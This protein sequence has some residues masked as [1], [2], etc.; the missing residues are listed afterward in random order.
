[1]QTVNVAVPNAHVKEKVETLEEAHFE[2]WHHW[3]V[4]WSAVWVGALASIGAALIFG[5]V[6]LALGAHVI[7]PEHRLVDL[8]KLS[9]GAMIFSVCGAFFAFAIGGWITG[10]VAGN[11]YAEPAILHGAIAWLVAIPLLVGFVA[12]GAG[13]YL[14][15][16]YSGL[17]GTP[18]WAASAALPFDR[19]DPLPPNAT[20]EDV[21]KYRQE[22]AAYRDRVQQWKDDTPKVTRN[23]ALGAVTALLLGLVGS[24][25]GGWVA[26]GEPM[27]FTH[28]R[29]R[30]L[31]PHHPSMVLRESM[32]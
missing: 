19:P 31:M 17:G 3:H 24:V 5:L 20:S 29:T 4:N 16:W 7:D 22:M 18:S 21:T 9:I 12:V 2:R 32:P 10:K 14:G 6:G 8:K 1:M 26:S 13:N 11:F 27:T 28:Y 23:A 15:G 30:K 25:I